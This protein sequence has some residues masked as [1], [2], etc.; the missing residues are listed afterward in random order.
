MAKNPKADA[1]DRKIRAIR[2]A[3]GAR[4]FKPAKNM[5]INN[6]MSLLV[7]ALGNIPWRAKP[8]AISP[9]WDFRASVF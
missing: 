4:D 2:R 9:I 5:F 7:I 8:V 6:L 3:C 1:I